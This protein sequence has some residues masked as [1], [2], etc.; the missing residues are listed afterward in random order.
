MEGSNCDGKGRWMRVG[1]LNMS[2]PNATCPPGLTLQEF[3]NIDHGVCGRPMSSSTF[4]YVH[5]FKYSNV[6]G[7]IRGYHF[8]SPDGFP[9]LYD[10]N[11]SPSIDSCNTYVD[12]VTFIYGSNPCKHIW[13]YACDAS[14]AVRDVFNLLQHVCPCNSDSNGTYV[15]EWIGS[16]YYYKSS[17]HLVKYERKSYTPMTHY[18]MDNNVIG[19]RTMLY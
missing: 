17:C 11:T 18:G 13:T 5:G 16:D 10:I 4:Y 9:P 12:G 6:C 8:R 19:I 14:E 2:E 3:A 1:Y 7:Q 15:A